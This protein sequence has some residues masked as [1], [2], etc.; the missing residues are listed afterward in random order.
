[1]RP[2]TLR[3]KHLANIVERLFDSAHA[4]PPVHFWQ[5]ITFWIPTTLSLAALLLSIASFQEAAQ[6]DQVSEAAARRAF[7]RAIISAKEHE[8]QKEIA[9]M[10]SM[11]G[12]NVKTLTIKALDGKAGMTCL[13]MQRS[14]REITELN[15][16]TARAT[17]IGDDYAGTAL[18][19]QFLA[20]SLHIKKWDNFVRRE[21]AVSDYWN[22]I[23]IIGL[24]FD[25]AYGQRFID[26]AA[27][28]RKFSGARM[29][30][31][32]YAIDALQN[33]VKRIHLLFASVESTSTPS[34]NSYAALEDANRPGK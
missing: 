24:H 4:T 5:S 22:K 21:D 31:S 28:D 32:R 26:C 27:E 1:M 18:A 34:D 20:E 9:L 14:A 15:D 16:A 13:E 30:L 19:N 25:L 7:W 29:H 17:E 10:K 12:I 33:D 8:R 2:R 23:A 6:H 3:E 11:D